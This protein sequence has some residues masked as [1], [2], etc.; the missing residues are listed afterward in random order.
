MQLT[1]LSV[2]TII[3]I[4]EAFKVPTFIAVVHINLNVKMQHLT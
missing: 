4:A 2:G 3:L 1:L